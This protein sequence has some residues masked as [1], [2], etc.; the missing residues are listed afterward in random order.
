MEGEE[1][2]ADSGRGLDQ[3]SQVFHSLHTALSAVKLYDTVKAGRIFEHSIRF[4]HLETET[5][6]AQRWF[7]PPDSELERLFFFA[8]LFSVIS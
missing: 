8:K 6:V 4:S 3:L 5:S 7:S 1:K 2:D